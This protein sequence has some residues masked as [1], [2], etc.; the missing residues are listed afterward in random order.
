[1]SWINDEYQKLDRS[2]RALRRFGII[3][4]AVLLLLG[5]LLLLG[6]RKAGGP[7]LSLGAL[8]LLVAAFAPWVLRYLYRPWMTV[9]FA[10]S[11]LVTRVI[12]T[13][14]FFLIVTPIGLLQRLCGKR[15]LEFRFQSDETSYWQSRT[16]HPVPADYE[17]QF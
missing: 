14:L 11:W 6:D 1:M 13:L 7:F 5:K 3:V 12:L 8:L 15:P 17:K 9:A 4:G 16:I 10:L 2:P